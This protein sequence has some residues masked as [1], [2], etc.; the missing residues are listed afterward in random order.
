MSDSSPPSAPRGDDPE[1][2]SWIAAEEKAARANPR[3]VLQIRRAAGVG[4]AMLVL[5]G[6]RSEGQILPR[7]YAE[8]FSPG[9]GRYARRGEAPFVAQVAHLPAPPEEESP[10]LDVDDAAGGASNGESSGRE[11]TGGE[12]A[13]RRVVSG[14]TRPME[15]PV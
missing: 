11:G 7:L 1:L 6:D 2:A 4:G 3:R 13:N 12:A 8:R 9:R 14:H 15:D 5:S 10:V